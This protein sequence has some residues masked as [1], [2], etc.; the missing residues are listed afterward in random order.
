MAKFDLCP[1]CGAVSR[2]GL[3]SSCGYKIPGVY[4]VVEESKPANNFSTY[5]ETYHRQETETPAEQPEAANW[6]YVG[7]DSRLIPADTEK[8][9][10]LSTGA[11]I[12]ILL[13]VMAVC[14]GI[15]SI[16]Y[17][18]GR[19]FIKESLTSTVENN[20]STSSK[21]SSETVVDV[22]DYTYL[23]GNYEGDFYE[24]VAFNRDY[25][26]MNIASECGADP[27][28]GTNPEAYDFDT[29][30]SENVSYK[31]FNDYWYY[32]NDEGNYD[33]D[34]TVF[35]H[36]LILYGNLYSLT[37]TGLDN[38]EEINERI[39]EEAAKAAELAEAFMDKQALYAHLDVYST[40]Y[41]TYMDENIISI[42]YY[43]TA[44]YTPYG[45]SY[46]EGEDMYSGGTFISSVNFDLKTG[47]EIFASKTFDFG[48]DFVQTFKDQ[49]NNQNGSPIDF[50]SDE[51]LERI[52]CSDSDVFWVYTPLGLEV[53]V[54]RPNYEGWSTGTFTDYE[55]LLK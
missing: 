46:E 49:C 34:G 44:Y 43:T 5:S 4:G 51:E 33:Y 18:A 25:F 42:A 30:I 19:D 45:S 53:G 10:G 3:C 36:N 52:M 21:D 7:S 24:L 13:L 23:Y 48:G 27:Y 12:S 22:D 1:K 50:Y 6:G 40:S 31:V 8:K 29:Y 26:C 11:I 16:S 54:N 38:E 55:G 20:G 32:D 39:Y 2:D 41:V 47:K 35:P 15:I 14:C 17:M 9:K 28:S 37:D